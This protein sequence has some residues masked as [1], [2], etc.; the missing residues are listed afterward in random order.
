MIYDRK[1]MDA[2]RISLYKPNGTGRDSYIAHN[3]G[4]NTIPQKLSGIV[5]FSPMIG[6]A[7]KDHRYSS[8]TIH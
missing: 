3:N 1:L 7:Y 2:T 5:K 6:K 8:S 4:G